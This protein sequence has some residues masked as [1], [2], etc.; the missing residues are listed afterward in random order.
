[1]THVKSILIA[2]IFLMIFPIKSYA[3]SLFFQPFDTVDWALLGGT[4]LADI[5]D[6]STSSDIP[7]YA[8]N[9]HP[10]FHEINP[11]IDT[12]WHTNI[13]SQTQYAITFAGI[14]AI[15][16][17][18]AYALPEKYYIRKIAMS[19][20]IT[21]GVFDTVRNVSMGLKFVW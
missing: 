17:L 3:G 15:Q 11:A 2:V 4:A 13:P 21:C 12:L 8:M 10:G 9:G 16:S 20:F 5:G 18:I 19:S 1:M 6:M 14:F 7:E